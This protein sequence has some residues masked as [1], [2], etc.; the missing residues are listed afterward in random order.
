MKITNRKNLNEAL[1]RAVQKNWY[2]GEGESRDYSVTGLLNP[3]RVF[4]LMKRHFDELE[5]DVSDRIWM[6]MGSAMHSVLE[7]ANEHDAEDTILSRVREFFDMIHEGKISKDPAEIESGFAKFITDGN[8]SRESIGK[9]LATLPEDRFLI[10]KRFRYVTQ[11]GKVISGGIDLYDKK[12][13]TLHDYKFTSV[14]TWLY[15]NRPGSRTQD[16]IEQLNMYRLFMEQQGYEVNEL[17]INLIFRDYSKSK[18]KFESGYP[19]EIETLD[20]PLLG[21]DIVEQMIE[22]KV[23][24]LEKYSLLD[25]DSLP[26]CTPEERWQGHDTFAV[27]KI[28]NKVASKVEY[29][30]SGAKKWLDEEVYKIASKDIAKGM[31]GEKAMKRASDLF[32]IEKRQAEPTRCESFCSVRNF[33]NFWQEY[34]KKLDNK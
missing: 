12:T 1:L 26:I 27:K 18:A 29:S 17:K 7:R 6:L 8:Q 20:L 13:K 3:V 32:T 31:D 30:Y 14:Y 22:S 2:S 34:E 24:E 23:G 10:E 21:L 33:C 9:L 25:D 5:E 16:W 4:H 28:G 11:S 15:R 19:D